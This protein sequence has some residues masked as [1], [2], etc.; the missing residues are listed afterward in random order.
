MAMKTFE[1]LTGVHVLASCAVSLTLLVAATQA[2][3]GELRVLSAAAMQSVW[4]RTASASE[5]DAVA[6]GVLY[7]GWILYSFCEVFIAGTPGKWLTG[8]RI[9]ALNG[10]PADK[11]RLFLRW[12]TKQSPMICAGL[13]ALSTAIRGILSEIGLFP[14]LVDMAVE[15]PISMPSEGA[16]ILG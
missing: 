7:G 13:F 3:A 1:R 11:W 6:A 10:S 12:Q 8:L 16:F 14:L 2:G 5:A 9:R 4:Q 15:K